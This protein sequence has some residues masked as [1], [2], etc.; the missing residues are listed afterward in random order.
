MFSMSNGGELT[1][2]GDSSVPG[3]ESDE[4]RLGEEDMVEL[5]ELES[6]HL[7]RCASAILAE[8][9]CAEVGDAGGM[10]RISGAIVVWDPDVGR[11]TVKYTATHVHVQSC[12]D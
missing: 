1:A 11:L 6:Q 12:G 5:E 8:A 3:V 10:T 9:S 4:P 7:L 2:V